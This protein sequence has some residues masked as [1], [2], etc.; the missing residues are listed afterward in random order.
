MA[1][2][3]LTA[4]D[5]KGAE[6]GRRT[7]TAPPDLARTGAF[8]DA[9]RA[10]YVLVRHERGWM[11]F[12]RD[13]EGHWH[14]LCDGAA[15]EAAYETVLWFELLHHY[16]GPGR[17]DPDHPLAGAP[18]PG[19]RGELDRA[20]ALRLAAERAAAGGADLPVDELAAERF[21]GGWYV[22]L[23][24]EVDDSDPMAFLESLTVGAPVFLVGDLGRVREASTS[25]PPD[26]LRERFRAEEVFVRRRPAEEAYTAEFA[27]AFEQAARADDTPAVAS[28]TVVDDPEALAARAAGLVDPIVQQLSLLGPPGWDGFTA[29][30]SCTVGAEIAQVRFR[31]GGREEAVRVPE[32]L[33][34]LV[35]RQR[36]LSARMPAGPWYRL[37]MAADTRPG[38][39]GVLTSY[40]YADEPLPADQLLPPAH[41]REDL[42]AYPRP[43]VPAW[44]TLH[45]PD[46]ADLGTVP[47][48]GPAAKHAPVPAAKPGPA[49]KPAPAPRPAP[50]PVPSP[51]VLESTHAGRRLYADTRHLVLGGNVLAFDE[52]DWVRYLRRRD[53][54]PRFLLPDVHS[55]MYGFGLGTA[56]PRGP[57]FE[58][59]GWDEPESLGQLVFTARGKTAEPPEEWRTLVELA[60]QY[61]EPRLLAGFAE[62]VAAGE[63]AV[64]GRLRLDRDGARN[65]GEYGLSMAWGEVHRMRTTGGYVSL[66]RAGAER[67]T[68]M[69][70]LD[71]PNAVLLPEL[72]R[73]FTGRP[74]E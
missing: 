47:K 36:H 1:R 37:V 62:R 59:Y 40:D 68:L 23:P 21:A 12:G 53:V 39:A 48:P 11:A 66:Y 20:D 31:Y 50:A 43:T 3:E 61:V 34:V 45:L 44:L 57:V 15:E 4:I 14:I 25:L 72:V 67:A 7:D 42:L 71:L 9:H 17:D 64:I 52:V 5:V 2:Y 54:T 49:A 24:V 33:A 74:L 19:P 26:V 70:S 55:T 10:G 18:A 8:G 51:P 16:P 58:P 60:R 63:E 35:R 32:D 65:E 69:V 56:D 46:A 6:L 38:G 13:G 41:Y 28:F 29:V 30:F 73:R 27:A 22:Y